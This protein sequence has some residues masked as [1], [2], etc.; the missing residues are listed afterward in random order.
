MDMHT[1]HLKTGTCAAVTLPTPGIAHADITPAWYATPLLTGSYVPPPLHTEVV[2]AHTTE[3]LPGPPFAAVLS[4]GDRWASPLPNV[5]WASPQWWLRY[6]TCHLPPRD[7]LLM[8][9]GHHPIFH[10]TCSHH[11]CWL[12]RT[13]SWCFHH[14][15]HAFWVKNLSLVPNSIVC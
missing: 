11:M 13:F 1:Q 6:R 5:E 10:I 14:R 2:I 15:K 4:L 9:F 3:L 12:K 7:M 8:C